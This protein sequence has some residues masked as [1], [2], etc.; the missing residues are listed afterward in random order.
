MLDSREAPAL[1]HLR[2]AL[3]HDWLTGMRGGER[4]LEGLCRLYPHAELFTMFH[5][6]GTVSPLLERRRPQ[7]SFIQRMPFSRRF[8]R[9]YL[10]L[11][12]TAIEQFDFDRFDVIV[13]TSHCAA[14]SVVKPGRA[15][16]LCY[17]FTPMRYAWDQFDA[18][19]GADRI[20]PTASRLMRPLLRRLARWDAAT[21]GRVDRYVAISQHVAGRLRCYYNR[22]AT[23]V[24]PPVD[25]EFF[26]PTPT[27]PGPAFL[28]VSALVPYKR[29]DLAIEAA[30]L[31]EVR[32]RIVGGGPEFGRLR[33]LAGPTVELLGTLSDDAVREEYRQARAFIL[34]GEEEFGIAPVEAQACGCPVVALNRGGARETVVDGVTGVLVDDPTT[35][36]FADAFRRVQTMSFDTAAIR[37][38]ALTFSEQTFLSQLGQAVAEMAAAPREAARW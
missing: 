7:V 36:A 38:H 26:Q 35:A 13:S 22:P 32:L 17:C 16:H 12:P 14:K 1:D 10:P 29:I 18:Y 4:A 2:I 34:P 27:E 20:G 24:Y 30:R 28:I 3:V 15:R 19:F 8:Y 37:A 9:H 31:A 11:F 6:P 23:V 21:A 25:T 5:H 33:Q